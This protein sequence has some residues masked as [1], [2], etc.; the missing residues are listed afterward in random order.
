MRVFFNVEKTPIRIAIAI[1]IIAIVHAHRT[2][3]IGHRTE[4]GV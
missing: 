1:A 2:S 4:R 3:D